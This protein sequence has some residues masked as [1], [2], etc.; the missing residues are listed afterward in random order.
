MMNIGE[1]IK[2]KRQQRDLTQAELAAKLNVTP[3]AVSRWEM[4]I[5]YPDITMI[6]LISEA[7]W[8]T[9][10]ELL[11]SQ[12]PRQKGKSD[13]HKKPD[14]NMDVLSQSQADSIF[15]YIPQ[16]I[17]KKE[18]KVLIVDDA[19]FMRMMLNDILTHQ[20]H[21]VL[22]AKNGLECLD[23]LKDETVDVCVLDIVMPHMNGMDVL[24]K[25]KEEWP[26]LKVIMLSALSQESNVRQAMQLGADT[27]IVKPFSAE[28]LI[29]RV[30]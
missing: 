21:T 25:I 23:I 14:A 15:D 7:L 5:S 6:P 26:D 18:K 19:E 24:K 16:K 1:V 20:G 30:G 2:L 22:Q 10:D 11:C 3:Q 13:E 12:P 29:E 28:C 17:S 9:A 4:G 8:V 27:F